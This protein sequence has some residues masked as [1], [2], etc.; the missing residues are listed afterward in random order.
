MR[1]IGWV[2]LVLSAVAVFA[3]SAGEL[4]VV[5]DF[6]PNPNHVPLYV[7]QEL[8]WFDDAGL[9][10]DVVVPANVSDPLKLAAV[11]QFDIALTP[12][13]NFLIARAEELPLVSIA[14][15]IDRNLGGLLA[16]E[17]RGI[18]SLEDLRGRRIGYSLAPLEPVL[19]ETMLACAG[20]GIGEVEL[21]NV[22]FNTVVSLMSGGVDAIGAFR[23]YEVPQ[24]EL[25]GE[26][27]VFFPQEAFC[28]PDTYDIILVCR[29]ALTEDRAEDLRTFLTVLGRGVRRTQE[30]PE[31]AYALF[32]EALPELDDELNRR[33]YEA[34][35]PLFA[36]DLRHDDGEQWQT[37]QEYLFAHGLISRT[38]AVEALAHTA[39]LPEGT[40]DQGE[41][42]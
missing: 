18:A 6:F 20:V 5:L 17:S 10:V 16:R 34:T 32:I 42:N 22:G 8:G 19:W 27:P 13:I 9:S 4:T 7:A 37:L 3:T 1:R 28:I 11:G 35:V 24:V 33:S 2:V 40:D 30:S 26:A 25:L 29:E 36:S 38:F 23:N 31:E 39:F 15:L 14:A 41:G 12:Q 21:I